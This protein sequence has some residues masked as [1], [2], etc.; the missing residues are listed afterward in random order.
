MN[1]RAKTDM[2][3]AA[4]DLICPAG[5]IVARDAFPSTD[6]AL[7]PWFEQGVLEWTDE[8]VDWPEE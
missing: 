2:S 7:A 6:A 4:G 1:V 5:Y 8:P 3:D